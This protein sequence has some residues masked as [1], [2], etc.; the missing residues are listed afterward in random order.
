MKDFKWVAAAVIVRGPKT[1]KEILSARRTE[2]A[3]LA[4]GWELPGGGVEEGEDPQDTVVREIEEEL[5]CLAEVIEFLPGP[6][7]NQTWPLAEG[8]KLY[9]YLC[10]IAFGDPY[11]REQHDAIAWL[12]LDIAEEAV[13]WLE[14]DIPIVR[15][16]V[17]RIKAL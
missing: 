9:V 2:P 3:N 15:A 6:D 11:I 14:P 1:G 12:R 4:G 8:K 10:R 5:G 17:E 13:A 7:V 16:A